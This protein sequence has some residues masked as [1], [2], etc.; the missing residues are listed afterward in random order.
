MIKRINGSIRLFADDTS[1]YII[2]NLPEQAAMVLNADLQTIS[3]CANDWLVLFNANKTLFVVISRKLNPVQNSP[4]FTN[5]TI[6]AETTSHK[7]LGLTFTSTC[8]WNEH[9]NNIS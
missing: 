5:D 3:H 4:L 6:I 1:L 7:H 2:V 8:T 9:V